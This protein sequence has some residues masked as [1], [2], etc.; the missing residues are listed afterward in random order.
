LA[1][2]NAIFSFSQ[3]D[4]ERQRELEATFANFDHDGLLGQSSL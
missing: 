4:V 1:L 2:C 3:A